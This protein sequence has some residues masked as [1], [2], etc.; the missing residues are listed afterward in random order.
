MMIV[1]NDPGVCFSLSQIFRS[2]GHP[3]ATAED[4]FAA[5]KG[6]TAAL[7]EILISDLNMPRMSGFELLSIVRRRFPSI[8][9]IGMT[10][11]FIDRLPPGIAADAFYRKASG[12]QSIF[13]LVETAAKADMR[14]VQDSRVSAPIWVSPLYDEACDGKRV[15]IGC[16]ECLR[17]FAQAL[18]EEGA[19]IETACAH[20]HAPIHV[21]VVEEYA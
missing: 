17:A 3:V 10:G 13:H 4:G 7:P 11:A 8:Y 12:L 1:D 15:Y 19:P 20:C 2:M 21:A 18:D 5:L 6:L 14:W 9:V 16:P